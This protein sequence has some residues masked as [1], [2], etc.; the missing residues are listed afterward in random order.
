MKLIID[1]DIG[2]DIDDALALLLA[3]DMG[4]EL[5]GITTVFGDTDKRAR[6]ARALLKS[7]G[8]GYEKTPVLKGLSAGVDGGVC[9]Y[10]PDLD[11]QEYAPDNT[12]QE[13]ATDFII[14]SA[15]RYGKELTL[16][17]IGPLTNLARVIEKDCAA[18]ERV[19]KTIIMGGAF[20]KQYADWNVGCDAAAAK[21]VFDKAPKL[22][23]LGADV[24]HMLD[25]DTD[26]EQIIGGYKGQNEAV[27]YISEMFSLWREAHPERRAI[28]HDPLTVFYAKHPDCCLTEEARI[29]VITEGY[30][31]GLTLNIDTYKN[32]NLNP[33]YENYDLTR[34]VTVA[35][36]VDRDRVVNRMIECFK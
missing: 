32:T 11:S 28:L 6:I 20:F 16:L 12:E 23:C 31:R 9:Q 33:L 5:V 22:F 17:F 4:E 13:D 1:T 36:T 2:D 19:N 25:V 29:A 3:M 10:T 35:T 8:G 18:L 24:T 26:A 15:Y 27:G 21:T 34:K 14:E 30:A 7:F